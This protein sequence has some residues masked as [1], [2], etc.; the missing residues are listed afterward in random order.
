MPVYSYVGPPHLRTAT[1]PGERIVSSAHLQRVFAAQPEG[2]PY[3][4]D[5][6]GALRVAPRRSEHVSCAGGADVLAAGELHFPPLRVTNQSTGYCPG[7]ESFEA[8]RAALS[9]AGV[10][11]PAR[12]DPEIIF[13][14]CGRCGE[15]N[16]VKEAWFVCVFCDAD[17]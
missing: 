11:P 16:L 14:R 9:E 10:K 2:L 3:I 17:L 12:F 7:P 15:M 6:T 8:V 5:L 13:R 1:T 4:V